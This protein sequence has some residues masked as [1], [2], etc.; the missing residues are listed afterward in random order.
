M[1]SPALTAALERICTDPELRRRLA[2]AASDE[3][4]RYLQSRVA[5]QLEGIYASLVEP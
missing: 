3:V 1:T 4:G 5:E 2:G